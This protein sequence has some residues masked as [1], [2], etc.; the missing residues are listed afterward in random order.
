M[1]NKKPESPFRIVSEQN[2]L[3]VTLDRIKEVKLEKESLTYLFLQNCLRLKLEVLKLSKKYK[4]GQQ[5]TIEP[6][7]LNMILSLKYFID[8]YD[9]N[10]EVETK[11]EKTLR[12]LVRAG[13][14]A[15]KED[16]FFDKFSITLHENE[17][18]KANQII[19]A[20]GVKFYQMM[21]YYMT[22]FFTSKRQHLEIKPDTEKNCYVISYRHMNEKE[23]KDLE[24]VQKKIK[25]KN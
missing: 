7:V 4:E 5:P 8:Y 12:G 17:A 9:E 24:K 11:F 23:L 2:S 20:L 15:K 25:H 6:H 21:I 3:L 1:E 19:D 22:L 16:L 18:Y 14:R 10:W 13:L